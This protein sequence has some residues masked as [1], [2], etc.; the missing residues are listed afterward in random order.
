[1]ERAIHNNEHTVV[2]GC[3]IC[4]RDSDML[5]TGLHRHAKGMHEIVIIIITRVDVPG[6]RDCDSRYYISDYFPLW[7]SQAP[8]G[9]AS[10]VLVLACGNQA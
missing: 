10:R 3:A 2:K 6:R 9:Q 4:Y 1:M 7:A 5:S 8:R